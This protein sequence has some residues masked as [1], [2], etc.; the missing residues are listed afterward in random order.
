MDK[1][2]A[3]VTFIN[4]AETESFTLAAKKLNIPKARVSQRIKDLEDDLNVRLF[5]RST[6]AVRITIAGK[7]YLKE[8]KVLLNSL[9]QVEQS[10]KGNNDSPSGRLTINAL[11]P[12]LRWIM[13]PYINE[14]ISSY[15]EIRLN[16]ISND[17]LVNVVQQNIDLVIRGGVLEDSNL[18]VRRLCSIPFQFYASPEIASYLED[19][20]EISFL[21]SQQLISWFPDNEFELQWTLHKN[22]EIYQIKSKKY[23]FISDQDAALKIASMGKGICP[24][25]YLAADSYVK[26]GLLV[27]VIPQWA[28]SPKQVS[29]LYP[30]K[31]HLPKKVEIFIKWLTEIVSRIDFDQSH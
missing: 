3:I 17:N 16:I 7:A 9:Y 5:E 31:A 13:C 30:S 20:K 11:S 27:P 25:M 23:I 18:I 19:K 14:F 22:D 15:P 29:L 8:C 10:L 6:R 28:V 26:S 4:V 21:E 12:F 1:L 2:S 24:G